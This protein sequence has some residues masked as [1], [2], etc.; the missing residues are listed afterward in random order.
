MKPLTL[1]SGVLKTLAL[2]A[3]GVFIPAAL[4]MCP[5]L[6]LADAGPLLMP[7]VIWS[8]LLAAVA[9]TVIFALA[10]PED[11]RWLVRL[12][13]LALLLPCAFIMESW[14]DHF[15]N[16]SR[17]DP[18]GESMYVGVLAF[19]DVL[20]LLTNRP[21]YLSFVWHRRRLRYSTITGL[22]VIGFGLAWL[23]TTLAQRISEQY[24]YADHF[25]RLG[26]GVRW[27]DGWV[28]GIYLKSTTTTDD[29]LRHLKHFPRIRS[30]Y[31]SD[32]QI[33]DSGL[34]ELAELQTV[35]HLY[36]DRTT[37]TDRGL[38]HIAGLTRLQNLWLHDTA[39]TD[40]GLRHLTGMTEMGYLDLGKTK[41]SDAGMPNLYGM[42]KLYYLHLYETMVTDE[43]LRECS[44][45]IPGLYAYNGRIT[46]GR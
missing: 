16:F 25:L 8:L 29:D 32:T 44:R 11:R 12:A 41:V 7:G 43:G 23:V 30:L 9:V 20:A 22:V 5:F 6:V 33:S 36:L 1:V 3:N 19:L 28:T 38:G 40:A 21:L 14:I 45:R 31:L 13:Y 42:K 39:V 18:P 4:L 15:N 37:V 26:G 35:E 17:F 27:D 10:L 34:E 2:A 24:P 46:V